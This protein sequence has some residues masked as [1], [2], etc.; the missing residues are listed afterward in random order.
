[1]PDLAAGACSRAQNS[2]AQPLAGPKAQQCPA[3]KA[4]G[5]ATPLASSFPVLLS[6]T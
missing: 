4:H 5:I 1:M 6:L 3:H 2:H